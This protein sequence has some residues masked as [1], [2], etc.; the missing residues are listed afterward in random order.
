MFE[1]INLCCQYHCDGGEW[2]PLCIALTHKIQG[3]LQ[4]I[5]QL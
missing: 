5:V 4:N 3:V 2:K 1:Y